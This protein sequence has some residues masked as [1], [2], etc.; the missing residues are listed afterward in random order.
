MAERDGL[1]DWNSFKMFF[2]SCLIERSNGYVKIPKDKELEAMGLYDIVRREHGGYYTVIKRLKEDG[3]LERDFD[4]LRRSFKIREKKP[5]DGRRRG[6]KAAVA[7]T[8]AE[9]KPAGEAV[10]MGRNAVERAAKPKPEGI[11]KDMDQ[12]SMKNE[13]QS[14]LKDARRQV[15]SMR[16]I[17]STDECVEALRELVRLR[18]TFP[19]LQEIRE[20]AESRR[21]LTAPEQKENAKIARLVVNF[22]QKHPHVWFNVA[23]RVRREEIERKKALQN[24]PRRNGAWLYAKS[25]VQQAF[26]NIYGMEQGLKEYKKSGRN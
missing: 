17:R 23:D 9:E 25:S 26:I 18:S 10:M 22:C 8:E 24:D 11:M 13:K 15:L 4:F 2:T 12:P 19:S 21:N 16:T 14:G 20:L 3:E 6:R 1:K 7:G 5:G